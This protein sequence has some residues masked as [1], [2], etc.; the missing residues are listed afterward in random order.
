MA[1]YCCL[2]FQIRRNDQLDALD[3]EVDEDDDEDDELTT[4]ESASDAAS[5]ALTS[6]SD[7]ESIAVTSES[8]E[9]SDELFVDDRYEV[10]RCSTRKSLCRMGSE[11]T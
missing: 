3:D 11:V 7:D 6:S 10:V 4:E 1:C 2:F 9:D 5:M 8:D